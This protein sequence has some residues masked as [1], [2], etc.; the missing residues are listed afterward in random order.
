MEAASC[1]AL[2]T[3]G[4]SGL[5]MA[6]VEYLANAGASVVLLDL[7]DSKGPAI[8]E[9]GGLRIL[10]NCAGIGEERGVIVNTGSISAFD[11]QVGQAAYSA[12]KAGLAGMTLPVARDL[13]AQRIRVVTIAPGFVA[14]PMLE[15]RVV[16]EGLEALTGAIPP[17]RRG[18]AHRRSTPSWSVRSSPTRCSTGRRSGSTAPPGCRRGS[19]ARGSS[20]CAGRLLSPA[21]PRPRGCRRSHRVRAMTRARRSAGRAVAGRRPCPGGRS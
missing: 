2:V 16:A 12:S 7:P 17:I 1:A 4:A 9:L 18:S 14:T 20:G 15:R 13:A 11:G 21:L 10:V 3:G 19:G 5:G 6:R 8:A